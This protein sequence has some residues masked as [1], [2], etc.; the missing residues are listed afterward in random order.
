MDE[1]INCSQSADLFEHGGNKETPKADLQE[2]TGQK[3][4][5]EIMLFKGIDNSEGNG[6][7][8]SIITHARSGVSQAVCL[9]FSL[10]FLIWCLIWAC[11]FMHAYSLYT[12][13]RMLHDTL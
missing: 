7:L 5:S 13:S 11:K 12:A 6:S 2:V 3:V 9:P 1:M 10:F 8:F 4:E